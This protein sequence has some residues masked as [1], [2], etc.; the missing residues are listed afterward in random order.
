MNIFNGEF[1]P[2]N[3]TNGRIAVF[4][5]QVKLWAF[6]ISID[7]CEDHHK[8]FLTPGVFPSLKA[9]GDTCKLLKLSNNFLT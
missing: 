7:I 3:K 5:T 4:I 8:I 6:I 2:K 9:Q 1:Y